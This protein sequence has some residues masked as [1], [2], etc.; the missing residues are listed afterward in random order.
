MSFVRYSPDVEVKQPDEDELIEKVIEVMSSL[1]ENHFDK[2][3]HAIREVH[4]KSHAAVVGHMEIYNDLPEELAQGVFAKPTR[5]PVVI[6]FSS[7]PSDIVDD[8]VPAPH[9]MAIK[10]IGITGRKML[11]GHEGEV[12]QDFVLIGTIPIFPAGEVRQYWN[13]LRASSLV[14]L[15]DSVEE[16]VGRLAS[17]SDK[18]LHFF[19]IDNAVLD[20][21]GLR[22]EHPLEQTFYSMAALRYGDYVAKICVTP[23]SPEVKA[24]T[25][26]IV[27]ADGHPSIYRDLLVA[28]FNKN[29][30]EYEV[31]AQLCTNLEIM[32]V[33]DASV[34]WSEDESLYQPVAKIVIPRQGAYSPERRVYVDD[35]LSFTPWHAIQEHQPLGSIMRSRLKAYQTSSIFRHRMNAVKRVEPRDIREIPE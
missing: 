16:S 5:Y 3:R 28:F 17:A 26:K 15:P 18:I 22:N 23:L 10:A 34:R 25:G 13:L 35:M 33:E 24:L 27:D 32:P 29:G 19:G 14:M 4:A 30:A 8:R 12:T 2:H 6:R 1:N 7:S 31:R 11:P 20:V 9:G 21:A